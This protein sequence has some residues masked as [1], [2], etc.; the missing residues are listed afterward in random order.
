MNPIELKKYLDFAHEAYEG[1]SSKSKYRQKGS[2]PFIFHP[3][4]C[5][6]IL[7]NDTK[8]PLKEREIGCKALI[9]HDVLENTDL[10]LPNWVEN[11]VKVIVDKLT[12]NKDEIIGKE[13]ITMSPFT[14]LLFLTDLLASMYDN[15]VS[16]PKRKIWKLLT[17]LLLIDVKKNYGN[18]RIIQIGNTI[19]QNTDW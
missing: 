8:V 19:Y 1:E 7:I 9:L 5:A 14:K 12:F 17:R 2:V 18:I 10:E 15:Q 6:S 3:L 13:I 16:K 11:N 4:W